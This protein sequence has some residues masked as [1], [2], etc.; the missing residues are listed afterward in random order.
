MPFVYTPI[1][2]CVWISVISVFPLI[3]CG[4][5]FAIKYTIIT[6]TE[7]AKQAFPDIVRVSSSGPAGELYPDS[8]GDYYK[9][10]IDV[11]LNDLPVYQH[12][13]RD[14]RYIINNGELLIYYLSIMNIHIILANSWFITHE[15]LN[16]GPREF[17]ST[18]EEKGQI[19]DGLDWQYNTYPNC[20]TVRSEYCCQKISVFLMFHCLQWT[21]KTNEQ[22]SKVC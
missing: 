8:L 20:Q 7:E 2:H 22:I 6:E 17:I 4:L 9:L 21:R 19:A 16:S 11:T 14:D 15:I 12:S 1:M 18:A 13:A 10:T 5:Y 3:Y